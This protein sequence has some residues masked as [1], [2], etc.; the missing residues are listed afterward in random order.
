M[1]ILY[2]HLMFLLIFLIGLGIARDMDRK[3]REKDEAF[4][5]SLK[6]TKENK[7]ETVTCQE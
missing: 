2:F 5:E 1:F 4:L 6:Q 3:Q 7:G